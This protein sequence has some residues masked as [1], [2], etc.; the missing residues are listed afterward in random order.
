ME[1]GHAQ[2][3]WGVL[4]CLPKG[5]VVLLPVCTVMGVEVPKTVVLVGEDVDY[6]G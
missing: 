6:V 5:I 1:K 2:L 4:V 3:E